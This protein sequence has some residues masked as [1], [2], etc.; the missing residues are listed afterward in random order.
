MV[1][2]M[3]CLRRRHDLTRAQ[4]QEYWRTSHGELGVAS[5]GALGYRRYVQSHTAD[6][7]LNDSLRAS[8]GAPEPFDGVVEL[9][10]DD[11]DAIVATFS[12]PEG[13][14]AAQ[15]LLNDEL[16]FVDLEASPIFVV[17]EHVMVEGD[18]SHSGG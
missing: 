10:F 12:S 17:Q 6:I 18:V 5:A 15:A 8:R 11:T 14:R 7:A 13:R 9:W 16:N 2:L 4:F 3:F 1:K